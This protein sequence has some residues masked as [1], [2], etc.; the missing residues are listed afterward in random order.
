MVLGA[1][2]AGDTAAA[3]VPGPAFAGGRATTGPCTGRL[4]I[5]G[6]RMITAGAGR[7]CG[8][9]IRRGGTVGA[10]GV[11]AALGDVGTAATGALCC[12]AEAC[13]DGAAATAD[14]PAP[15]DVGAF[16]GTDA[17]AGRATGVADG[18]LAPA[19]SGDAGLGAPA[20]G[21]ATTGRTTGATW[22]PVAI[23]AGAF[24]GGR[25]DA[26][27]TVTAVRG[28]GALRAAASACLR[29]RIAFNASPGLDT[30]DRLK[31]CRA[32]VGAG[33]AAEEEER[34]P[35]L[36]WPRT[37]SASSSSME[38]ECVF[39]S[40]TPTAVNASRMDL[41]LT[42]S[43]RARSLIRTLLIRSFSKKLPFAPSWS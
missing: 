33:L 43:S 22:P 28:G 24:A 40:V 35:R 5:A 39:F 16:T 38:L 1:L 3:G 29:S 21:T 25:G 7:G 37:F 2:A 11:V 42:S 17:L 26:G 4:T 6:G 30:C 9:T 13:A 31:P 20:E 12:V 10:P 8:I 41:L 18:R 15:V 34:L 23:G 19:C 32:S 14:A 36:M 27:E